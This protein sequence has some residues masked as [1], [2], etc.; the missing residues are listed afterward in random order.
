MAGVSAFASL[1]AGQAANDN[2]YMRQLGITK[3]QE[4]RNVQLGDKMAETV[5]AGGI[6]KAM[7]HRQQIA[8]EAKNHLSR[9]NTQLSG[10]S[11]LYSY[12]N[13]SQQAEFTRGSINAKVDSS[14]RED[15]RVSQKYANQAQS[16]INEAE[17]HK[18]S[19]GAML[20]EAAV[21]G[22]SAYSAAGDFKTATS[23]GPGWLQS[24]TNW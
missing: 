23:K 20:F 5:H 4:S 15:G 14:L 16:G 10:Q 24:L 12:M 22:A 18:K 8:T 17:S 6:A 19:A 1:K 11:A 9:A 21:A 2:A 13:I 7:V 3:G